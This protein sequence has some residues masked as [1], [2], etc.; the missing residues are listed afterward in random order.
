MDSTVIDRRLHFLLTEVAISNSLKTSLQGYKRLMLPV[1]VTAIV[2]AV[3]LDDVARWVAVLISVYAFVMLIEIGLRERRAGRIED[4]LR[5]LI[6]T[7]E[8]GLLQSES[9]FNSGS[10]GYIGKLIEKRRNIWS[11]QAAFEII[12]GDCDLG[13]IIEEYVKSIGP[14]GGEAKP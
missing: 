2:A 5:G 14:E 1:L 3:S 11:T 4:A 8:F 13:K 10:I 7:R 12:N 9:D 6:L